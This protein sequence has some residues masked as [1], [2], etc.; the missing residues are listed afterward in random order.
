MKELTLTEFGSSLRL[1]T[2]AGLSEAEVLVLTCS[3]SSHLEIFYGRPEHSLI[4]FYSPS[5]DFILQGSGHD[6]LILQ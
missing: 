1:Q 3:G 4:P 5:M 2:A 6:I